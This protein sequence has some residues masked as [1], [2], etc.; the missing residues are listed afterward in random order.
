MDASDL[1]RAGRLQDAIDAQLAKVKAQP[2]DR[3]ARFFLFE[4]ALFAGDLDRARKQLDVLRYDDPKHSAAVEQYRAALESEAR[5]RAV[6]AGTEQP[7]GLTTAPDHLRMRVEALPYLAR[8][9]H[10]EARKRLDE[11]NAA[12]P[13]VKFLVNGIPA[14]GLYDADER[15]ATVLEV[16]GSG[17]VY[18]WVPL[19]QVE[20]ITLNPP[21]APRDV[22]LRPARV[23][24]KDGLDGDVLLP[25]LYPGTHEHAD[26][27]LRL[28]R[29]TEWL[30][31]ESEVTRGAG[32]KLFIAGDRTVRLIELL[33][34]AL[35]D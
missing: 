22:I 9:E 17:G 19:E 6:F 33:T 13:A 30:G 3:S 27:E 12:V 1:F 35:A 20:S 32:G 10:A 16:F 29:A 2:T 28:G 23:V 8:G 14:D 34:V 11:A 4:L 21:A 18:S 15:F 25:G 31:A 5:R 24:L 7:K 26:D